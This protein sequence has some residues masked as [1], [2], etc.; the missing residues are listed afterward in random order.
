MRAFA[1]A[2]GVEEGRV[3]PGTFTLPLGTMKTTKRGSKQYL[4]T[5]GGKRFEVLPARKGRSAEG[6]VPAPARKGKRAAN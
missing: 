3:L 6:I 4:T 2:L 1:E 5:S